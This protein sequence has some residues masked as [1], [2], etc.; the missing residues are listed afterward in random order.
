MKSMTIFRVFLFFIILI[1]GIITAREL[2]WPEYRI[3]QQIQIDEVSGYISTNY[4]VHKMV[5]GTYRRTHRRRIETLDVAEIFLKNLKKK[6]E[7][8]KNVVVKTEN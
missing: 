6:Y 1:I 4:V 5:G 8:E 2:F 7:T 3:V